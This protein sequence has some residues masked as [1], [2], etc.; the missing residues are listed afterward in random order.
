[1]CNALSAA[2]IETVDTLCGV[3]ESTSV[4]QISKLV[5]SDSLDVT[6][7]MVPS[8]ISAK[9]IKHYKCIT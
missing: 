9:Y 1:M 7:E 2:S 3:L 4:S 6:L 8:F 5:A